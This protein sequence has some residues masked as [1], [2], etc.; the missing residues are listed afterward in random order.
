MTPAEQEA[1]ETAR[2]CGVG[3]RARFSRHIREE[4][5][6]DRSLSPED[7]YSA[8]AN[9]RLCRSEGLGKHDEQKWRVFGPCV[10]GDELQ[11]IVVF[12]PHAYVIT[13]FGA[14]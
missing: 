5:F 2:Q 13:V 4:R 7:L 12:D 3:R 11:L 8:L 1:L 6:A 14:D 9:G 10:D